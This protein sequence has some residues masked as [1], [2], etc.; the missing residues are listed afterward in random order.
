MA[1]YMEIARRALERRQQANHEVDF[2]EMVLKG[3]AIELYCNL[4]EDTL[5]LVADEDDVSLL[6]EPRGTTYTATEVRLVCR[7]EDKAIVR[8]IH[9]YKRKFDGKVSDYRPEGKR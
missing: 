5:F 1:D 9:A 4:A 2:L 8:E 3:K 6:G 7:I